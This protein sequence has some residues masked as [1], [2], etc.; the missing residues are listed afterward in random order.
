ML[1]AF[2][3]QVSSRTG[4]LLAV[5]VP[6]L[7][8]AATV[9]LEPWMAGT[10]LPPTFAGVVWVALRGGL[11]PGLVSVGIGAIGLQV[12]FLSPLPEPLRMDASSGLRL[13]MF[14][15]LSV[16]LVWVTA[17]L[18]SARA[19][20]EEATRREE[21]S[22]RFLDAVIEHI[23][24][25]VFV[26]DAKDLRFTLFNQAGEDLLGWPRSELLGSTDRAFFP[27]A[28]TLHFQQKDREVLTLRS[29]MEIPEE[30][31]S[32]RHGE[33][34]L[35]TRKVPILDPAGQPLY[36][37]GVSED[38]TDAKAAERERV[39]L[40]EKLE[41][42]VRGREE[43]VA[44]V[45]HD[46]RAPLNTILLGASM[47]ARSAGTPEAKQVAQRVE[48]ASAR[49]KRLVSDLLDR[50]RFEGDGVKLESKPHRLEALMQETVDVFQPLA[51]QRGLTLRWSPPPSALPI[52][53]LDKERILQVLAN[54]VS[55]AILHS[56]AGSD[57]SLAVTRDERGWLR[58][59]VTD[60]GPGIDKAEQPRLFDRYYRTQGDVAQGTGL[61][62]YIASS[63]VKAHGGEVGVDSHPGDGST[64]WFALRPAVEPRSTAVSDTAVN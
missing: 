52:A 57:I 29:A 50:A 55:N 4:Y 5:L 38:I 19:R 13:G 36:V 41:A 8:L 32:T 58:A 64:F 34:V 42:A 21:K 20:A 46:L 24:S 18:R 9:A 59:S 56:P 45:S 1:R 11:G 40:L 48:L 16:P 27:E 23:P 28:E 37:L 7:C 6:G 47:L 25:M 39:Q 31:I 44:V 15:L 26:K 61:G 14:V 10:V 33:R 53:M 49:V 22:R 17:S 43:V 51:E 12:L 30:T 60:H 62:L 63:I 3:A 35:R 2:R 54:F